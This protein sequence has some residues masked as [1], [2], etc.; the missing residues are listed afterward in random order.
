MHSA[1]RMRDS[2]EFCLADRGFEAVLIRGRQDTV[3]ELLTQHRPRAVIEIG[4]GQDLVYARAAD[5]GFGIERWVIVE[6]GERLA[7]LARAAARPGLPLTVLTGYFEDVGARAVQACV[8]APQLVL[9]SGVLPAVA[10]PSL[11]LRAI[12][13]VLT[14]GARL[15]LVVPNAR[16]LHRRLARAMGLVADEKHL[17]ERDRRYFHLHSFDSDDLQAL[18]RDAGFVV[19]SAGGHFVK[20]FTHAQME[21]IAAVLTPEV[22]GGLERLGRQFPDLASEI[23]VT[24]RVA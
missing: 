19:E 18:A 15:H 2:E 10:E 23:H 22:L 13:A 11:L 3:L 7:E 9:C 1:D 20:P 6:P 21:A 12:R 4:C 5:A 17:S 16:S 14:P 24:A 8:C